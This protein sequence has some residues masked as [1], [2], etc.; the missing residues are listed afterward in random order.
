MNVSVIGGDSLRVATPVGPIVDL[1][2]V[3]KAAAPTANVHRLE[4]HRLN[5]RGL[6]DDCFAILRGQGFSRALRLVA[7]AHLRSGS[8]VES[9]NI[10]GAVVLN[11]LDDVGS[12]TRENRCDH[13]RYQHANDNPEHCKRA[14]KL[15]RP[16][17]VERHQQRFARD[18]FWN[19]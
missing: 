11:H 9:V 3:V 15:V 18:E 8:Q 17:A 13:D 6:L 14:P 4:R 12:Q 7:L 10:V 1:D 2:R 19:P 5:R 16:E